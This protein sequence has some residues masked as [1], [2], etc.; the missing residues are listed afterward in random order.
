[1]KGGVGVWGCGSV[2]ERVCGKCGRRFRVR[3][4]MGK[5]MCPQ[6]GE[7]LVPA[8]GSEGKRKVSADPRVSEGI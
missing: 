6:C 1:M 7:V 5:V 3:V 2:G 4:G 8:K